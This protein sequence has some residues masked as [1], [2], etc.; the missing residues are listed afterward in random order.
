MNPNKKYNVD[1]YMKCV[2]QIVKMG[3]HILGIK[4]MAGLLKPAAAKM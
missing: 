2:H 4:D 1:Y 3:A